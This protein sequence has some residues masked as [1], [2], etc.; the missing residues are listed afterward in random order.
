MNIYIGADHN[1][2]EMK[3]ELAAWLTEQGH[4]VT[5]L[6]ASEFEKADDYPDFGIAVAKEVAQ[7]PQTRRGVLVCGS[8]VGMAVAAGKVRGIRAAVIHDP[9]IAAAAQR[10]DDI[11]VLAIGAAYT[12]I[13]NAKEVIA[14]WLATPFSGEDRHVRRISKIAEYEN[15]S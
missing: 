14:N 7:E 2:F 6:G 1:G 13:A 15:E 12:D 8:G 10:D 9:K 5:D 11:N 3:N 4:S